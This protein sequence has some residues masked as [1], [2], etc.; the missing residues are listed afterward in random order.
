MHYGDVFD[1]LYSSL[2]DS[3]ILRTL[4]HVRSLYGIEWCGG[5]ECWI[6][7]KC[8]RKQS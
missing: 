3:W 7:K 2:I 4:H 6:E 1:I 8:R 5:S